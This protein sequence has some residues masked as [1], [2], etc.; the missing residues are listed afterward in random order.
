MGG[1]EVYRTSGFINMEELDKKMKV[2][3]ALSR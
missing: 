3:S 1:K 2:Y